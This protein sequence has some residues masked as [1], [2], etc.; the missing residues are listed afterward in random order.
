MIDF[1]I[2]A[3][4]QYLMNEEDLKVFD[5]LSNQ[6][7]IYRGV[8][9]KAGMYELSWTLSLEKARWFANRFSSSG[10]KSIK[11]T[12]SVIFHAEESRK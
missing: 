6:V 8:R 10:Y 12:S 3:D 1:F 4:K 5:S 2:K 11:P 9:D 7:T